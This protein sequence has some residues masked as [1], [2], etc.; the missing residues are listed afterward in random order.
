MPAANSRSLPPKRN[1]TRH[2]GDPAGVSWRYSPPPSLSFF[3]PAVPASVFAIND[4]TL[5]SL[6]RLSP[7]PASFFIVPPSARTH[8][9]SDS[10]ALVDLHGTRLG[11]HDTSEWP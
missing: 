5:R 4:F 6:S 8:T 7:R 2:T 9:P 3:F 10:P 1:L 11:Q